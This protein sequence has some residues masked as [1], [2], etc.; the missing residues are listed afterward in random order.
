MRMCCAK[1]IEAP[2][3]SLYERFTSVTAN[4]ADPPDDPARQATYAAAAWAAL[5]L[6]LVPATAIGRQ[7]GPGQAHQIGQGNSSIVL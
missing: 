7:N 6:D 1:R 2:C 3:A 5:D 4:I